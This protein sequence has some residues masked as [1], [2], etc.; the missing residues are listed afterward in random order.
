MF[1]SPVHHPVWGE[2]APITSRHQASHV[3]QHLHNPDERW[4]MVLVEPADLEVLWQ[5]A[6]RA[7]CPARPGPSVR[8]APRPELGPVSPA[9]A[10]VLRRHHERVYGPA[11][12]AELACEETRWGVQVRDPDRLLCAT[13]GGVLVAVGRRSRRVITAFRPDVPFAWS[14][15]PDREDYRRE[16][17]RRWARGVVMQEMTPWESVLREEISV[18]LASPVE[19]PAQLAFALR[20]MAFARAAVASEASFVAPVRALERQVVG[21]SPALRSRLVETLSGWKATR[22]LADALHAEDLDLVQDALLAIEDTLAV[23]GELGAS[24]AVAALQN[25]LSE[26]LR[27]YPSDLGGLGRLAEVRERQAPVEARVLWRA[28]LARGEVRTEALVLQRWIERLGALTAEVLAPLIDQVWLQPVVAL[29]GRERPAWDVTCTGP[30]EEGDHVALFLVTDQAPEGERLVMDRDYHLEPGRW[31]FDG[32]RLRGETDEALLV[33]VRSARPVA[34]ELSAALL[35]AAGLDAKV[36][37][38]RLSP[39]SARR[40]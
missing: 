20:A 29:S 25:D 37:V 4:E 1:H 2:I 36:D 13:P 26:A 32:L 21:A 31:Q 35:G 5:E 39:P 17:V 34:G 19:T 10:A 15:R 40:P 11:Y 33:V 7:G 8:G 18:A 9:C 28:V 38:R 24:G 3:W 16:A 23:L 30:V 6:A 22:R 27:A 12:L 14:E